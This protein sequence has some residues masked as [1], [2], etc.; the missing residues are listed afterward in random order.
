MVFEALPKSRVLLSRPNDANTIQAP[1][2]LSP[3]SLLK[4]GAPPVALGG[5]FACPFS[6]FSLCEAFPRAGLSE[7]RAHQHISLAEFSQ[8]LSEVLCLFYRYGH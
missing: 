7:H 4:P 1:G 5:W 3:W 2:V 6:S 8:Q